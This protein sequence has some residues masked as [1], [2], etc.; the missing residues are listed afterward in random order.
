M[1]GPPIGL[2]IYFHLDTVTLNSLPTTSLTT[3]EHLE[4]NNRENQADRELP[5]IFT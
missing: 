2:S 4:A 3:L 1:R 5:T